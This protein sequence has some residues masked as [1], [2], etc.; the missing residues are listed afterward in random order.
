MPTTPVPGGGSGDTASLDVNTALIVAITVVSFTLVT[1]IALCLTYK[2]HK[3][4][5]RQRDLER[6][7]N[8]GE[9]RRSNGALAPK[10]TTVTPPSTDLS[11]GPTLTQAS[12]ITNMTNNSTLAG[13]T[14]II[15]IP[16]FLQV[17]ENCDYVMGDS[18]ASGGWGGIYKACIIGN[19][20]MSRSSSEYIAAKRLK[21]RFPVLR[22]RLPRFHQ[23]FV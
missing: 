22:I 9:T 13:K 19:D 2:Y 23:C 3:K 20:L 15:A 16:G 5:L 21:S 10:K 12:N 17:R 1:S 11:E 7:K 4:L 8:R 6:Q 18:I 14:T